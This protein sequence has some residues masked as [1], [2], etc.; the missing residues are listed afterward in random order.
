M[1]RVSLFVLAVTLVALSSATLH[2][3]TAVYSPGGGFI[4]FTD[5]NGVSLLSLESA[6]GALLPPVIPPPTGIELVGL[7]TQHELLW[8]LDEVSNI[9][10]TAGMIVQPNTPLSDL[11]LRYTLGDSASL[12]GS[13]II[14]P[15]PS[16]AA[17]LGVP[18]AFAFM[19]RRRR[20]TLAD[21][22]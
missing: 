19:T 20:K 12:P 16:S 15:E 2:A 22:N 13:V 10:F 7:P 14:F 9:E 3:A 18:I 5:L 8:A 17:L 1:T 21:W 4:Y 6:S 11:S